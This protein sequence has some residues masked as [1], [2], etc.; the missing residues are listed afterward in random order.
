MG[1]TEIL[2]NPT[3][4]H[5]FPSQ[6]HDSISKNFLIT[7]KSALADILATTNTRKQSAVTFEVFVLWLRNQHYYTPDACNR[8]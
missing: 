1:Q 8:D 5:G 7:I 4:C 2:Y 3:N 6:Q